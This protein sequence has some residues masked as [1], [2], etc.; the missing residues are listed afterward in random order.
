MTDTERLIM[1]LRDAAETMREGRRSGIADLL[2]MAAN[3]IE[4]QMQVIEVNTERNARV[5]SAVD[6]A[7]ARLMDMRSIENE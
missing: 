4:S 2:A 6:A 3:K 1:A 7:M 5:R